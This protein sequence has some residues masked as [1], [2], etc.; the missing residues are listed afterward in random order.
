MAQGSLWT[1]KPER[2]GIDGKL[3]KL[4]IENSL[5]STFGVAGLSGSRKPLPNPPACLPTRPCPPT[6]CAPSLCDALSPVL[7][8]GRQVGCA[9]PFLQGPVHLLQACKQS[10]RQLRQSLILEY[11]GRDYRA[12][13]T[14]SG[15][16]NLSCSAI[17]AV[18]ACTGKH[19]SGKYCC[20]VPDLS[21][22][23]THWH[24]LLFS[25]KPT[26]NRRSVLIG[27]AS[28]MLCAADS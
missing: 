28:Q 8:E 16:Q 20:E 22:P 7:F 14:K 18:E 17:H 25:P 2:Q 24:W 19:I 23:F 3:N 26:P 12:S 11:N 27:Q 6:L 15:L 4:R 9:G 13:A 10:T 5:G 1:C 21:A